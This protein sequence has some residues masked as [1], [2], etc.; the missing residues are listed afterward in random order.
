MDRQAGLIALL[1][2]LLPGAARGGEEDPYA[3]YV[4]KAPEFRPVERIEP[5]RWT[6][7][8]YMPWRWKWGHFNRLFGISPRYTHQV[9]LIRRHGR[10]GTWTPEDAE[11]GF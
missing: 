1:L 11:R 7:W 3:R 4:R 10:P 8:T 5:K 2:F 9:Q 6:T